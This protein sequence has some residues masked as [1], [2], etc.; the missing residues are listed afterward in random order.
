[1]PDV[2]ATGPDRDE[3]P[4]T[5]PSVARGLGVLL[6]LAVIA[7]LLSRSNLLSADAPPRAGHP[8][9]P[10]SPPAPQE[11]EISRLIAQ[12]DDHLVRLGQDD[13]AEGPLLPGPERVSLVPVPSPAGPG[14]VAGV[15]G[16]Q[17]FSVATS[18]DAHWAPIGGA[19]AVVAASSAPGR[20]LV[21]RGARV[22][23][24]EVG[25]GRVVDPAPFP[26]FDGS[27][28]WVPAGLVTL[29]N[30]RALLLRRPVTPG[31][32]VSLALAW[33]T[34][35][36]E[37]GTN[38]LLQDLG[39]HGSLM[40]IADDWVL[41]RGRSCPGEGCTVAVVTVTRDDVLVRDVAPPQGWEFAGGPT[42][43]RTHEALVTVRRTGA[44]G[45]TVGL[46]RLVPGGEN[47]LL[48]QGTDDV[49]LDAGLV[50]T[51]AG[52][53]YFVR[54][55]SAGG[56][57]RVWVWDPERPGLAEPVPGATGMLPRTARL[58]CVCG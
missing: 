20:L 46:A 25:H 8:S 4:G 50:D 7:L 18:R 41:T 53:V 54:R 56:P 5:L 40:G 51:D 23:E 10:T 14:A 12:V 15:A 28:G 43:G 22:V 36:V 1:M 48:V 42:A 17:L 39:S 35:R 24:V 45:D 38:P 19:S 2:I 58:V 55:G 3:P 44:A 34:R 33:P 27:G 37:A 21:W 57:E 30:T 26:G 31:R 16:A 6:V 11:P 9:S 49:D 47:A 32:E 13:W 29:A 52:T